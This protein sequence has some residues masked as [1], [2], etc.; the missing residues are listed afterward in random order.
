MRL[1]H[2]VTYVHK[3]LMHFQEIVADG[4]VIESQSRYCSRKLV[5]YHNEIR[6][7]V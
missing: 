1:L 6:C 2:F 3:L 7:G 4:L 5:I